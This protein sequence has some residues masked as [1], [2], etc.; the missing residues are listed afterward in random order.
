M[1]HEYNIAFEDDA[2]CS[3]PIPAY[4]IQVSA[5]ARPLSHMMFEQ[6]QVMPWTW[7]R[8]GWMTRE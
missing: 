3:H 5:G 6:Y 8:N 1:L 4:T 2:R 7:N